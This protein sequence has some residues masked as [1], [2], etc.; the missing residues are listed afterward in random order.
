MSQDEL[1]L[2]NEAIEH[3]EEIAKKNPES[4]CAIQH[5][6]L[7]KWLKELRELKFTHS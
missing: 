4:P 6:Q 3:A 2:L 1:A 5:G 7:A